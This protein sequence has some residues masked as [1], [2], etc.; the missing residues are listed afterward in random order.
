MQQKLI[1]LAAEAVSRIQDIKE[2]LDA[3]SAEGEGRGLLEMRVE[4]AMA[5]TDDIQEEIKKESE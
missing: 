5:L 2:A 3:M 1:A 4:D